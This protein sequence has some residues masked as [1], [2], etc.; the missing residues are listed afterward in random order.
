MST[1]TVRHTSRRLLLV[2]ANSAYSAAQDIFRSGDVTIAQ[3]SRFDLL[4]HILGMLGWVQT[5]GVTCGVS[6]LVS[7]LTSIMPELYAGEHFHTAQSLI[8]GPNNQPALEL[9]KI[10]IYEISNGIE[11]I[12][13]TEWQIISTFLRSCLIAFP[14]DIK[15]LR[16]KSIAF[17]AFFDNLLKQ[18]VW[19]RTGYGLSPSPPPLDTIRWL[20]DLGQNPNCCLNG[21][22]GGPGTSVRNAVEVG[23]LKLIQ[24]LLD[25]HVHVHGSQAEFELRILIDDTM[26]SFTSSASKLRMLQFLSGFYNCS[27]W[28]AILYAAIRLR[29][30]GLV[31]DILAH[32]P[33][34]IERKGPIKYGEIYSKWNP[35]TYL[36]FKS[37]LTAAAIAGDD[38]LTLMLDRLE[39]SGRLVN[40]ITTDLLIAASFGRGIDIV[41]RL[42]RTHTFPMT[43]NSMGTTPLQAA[44]AGGNLPVCELYLEID[45]RVS[46]ALIA[47]A[48]YRGHEDVLLMLISFENC[49]NEPLTKQDLVGFIYALRCPT[50]CRGISFS[51]LRTIIYQLWSGEKAVA[52]CLTILIEA[53][54]RFKGGEIAKLA[55]IGL[56]EPLRAALASGGSPDDQ[57]DA[58]LSALECALIPG[59]KFLMKMKNCSLIVEILLQAKA[60][61]VGGEVVTA[62]GN[63]D[64]ASMC[65]LLRHGGTLKDTNRRGR[66]CLEAEILAQNNGL[67]QQILEEANDSIDLAPLCAALQMQD[68]ELVQRLLPR[69]HVQPECIS[70]Q[71]TA[72]GLA[73]AS[74]NL[75]ILERLHTH[76]SRP[77]IS[78]EALLP[79]RQRLDGRLDSMIGDG[80]IANDKLIGNMIRVGIEDFAIV[81][82]CKYCQFTP[83]LKA[84]PLAL[85]ALGGNHSGFQ[86][87]LEKGYRAD[88]ITLTI[89]AEWRGAADFVELLKIYQ[90]RLDNLSPLPGMITPLCIAIEEG[91]NVMTNYLVEA[92]MDVNGHD[93]TLCGS[94]S[95]LQSAV[96]QGSL[97]L[98]SYLLAK[99]ASVNSPPGIEN[100][101]TALQ[102]A[103]VGGHIGLAN[104]LLQHGARINARGT[105]F[106]GSA[107]ELAACYGNIDM[108]QLFL[109]HGAITTGPG[110]EQFVSAVGSAMEN[111][112]HTAVQLLKGKCGWTKADESLLRRLSELRYSF[113][114][115]GDGCKICRTYCCD[116][117]H[118]TDI[119]CI[120]DYSKEEEDNFADNCERCNEPH[121][122][123]EAGNA[124]HMEETSCRHYVRML[125]QY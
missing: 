97:S 52:N 29:D 76:F 11:R 98:T 45:G 63:R 35:E 49:V 22:F 95:P 66:T 16:T 21:V 120:H 53:G 42:L 75:D 104:M 93:K 92:G 82:P 5:S 114:Y 32:D 38:F 77:L 4:P 106:Q 55:H 72:I 9:F 117:I 25:S 99:G 125:Q 33:D 113:V 6:E 109:R 60:R 115:L 110:R 12:R 58:G 17:Q 65:L 7:V 48:A 68:R 23:D 80:G 121:I 83:C 43:C 41:R 27:D 81:Y 37:P 90:P 13:H 88:I 84:S 101:L 10:L 116:E 40:S 103:V 1:G 14:L 124:E 78:Y 107:L 112:Y 51:T 47:L 15:T 87:L 36:E 54:A 89:L 86:R 46:P 111:A 102:A 73:A 50:L 39:G 71:G 57:N 69:L 59:G 31:R 34:A 26:S 18:E 85:A 96:R 20:L 74:G 100:G 8:S 44:V 119:P 70:M 108:L 28:Q 19:L 24:L 91:N 122:A 61:L 79:F 30:L 105:K 56:E 118:D 2:E 123:L 64:E 67:I 94:Y 62:I 3:T